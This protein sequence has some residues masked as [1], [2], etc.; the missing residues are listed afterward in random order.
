[1]KVLTLFGDL[2]RKRTGEY[3]FPSPLG[4]EGPNTVSLIVVFLGVPVLFPSPLG[5]EGPNT[6][7]AWPAS[8]RTPPSFRPLS[9]MKVLTRRDAWMVQPGLAWVSVPSRG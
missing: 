3:L 2:Y 4:D 9:G 8:S 7:D 5:D 1:M 6:R